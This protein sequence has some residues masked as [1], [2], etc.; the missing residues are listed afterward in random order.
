MKT[1]RRAK[2]KRFRFTVITR[3]WHTLKRGILIASLVLFLLAA[4]ATFLF[5]RPVLGS[6]TGKTFTWAGGQAI[7]PVV[8]DLPW[9]IWMGA[10]GVCVYL[11]WKHKLMMSLVLGIVL[12]ILGGMVL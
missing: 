10:I 9:W 7:S 2:R 11:W 12:G 8:S 6:H 3:L 4:L 1:T 5:L